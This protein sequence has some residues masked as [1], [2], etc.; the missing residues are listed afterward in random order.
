MRNDQEKSDNA[1]KIND[2]SCIYHTAAEATVMKIYPEHFEVIINTALESR[3]PAE[4]RECAVHHHTQERTGNKSDDRI[5][6]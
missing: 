4:R 6:G 1:Y 3:Y 2:V 5:A